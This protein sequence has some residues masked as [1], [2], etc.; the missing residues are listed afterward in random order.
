VVAL[1]SVRRQLRLRWEARS[2]VVQVDVTGRVEV[3]VL[4]RPQPVKHSRA[5]VDGQQMRRLRRPAIN[6]ASGSLNGCSHDLSSMDEYAA[7]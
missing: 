4:I 6:G 3:G 1:N 5:P 7:G 2:G